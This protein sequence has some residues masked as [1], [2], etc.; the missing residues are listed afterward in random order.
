MHATLCDLMTDIIQNAVEAGATEIELTIRETAEEIEFKVKDNG[1]GMSSESKAKAVDP[2]YSDG[3]KH[4]HR[5][6]G[7]GLSFLFQTA[8]AAGGEAAIESQEGIGTVIRFRAQA[9]HVDLPPFGDFPVAAAMMLTLLPKG[10]MCINRTVGA[11]TYRLL[12]SE[13]EEALG[14]LDSAE[15]L[16]ML[17]TFIASQEEDLRKAG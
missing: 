17:K 13:L 14:G 3:C 7:L 9:H 6:V 11:K 5:R 2:F 8:E 10:E 1:K 16:N 15:N 12:R 4:A